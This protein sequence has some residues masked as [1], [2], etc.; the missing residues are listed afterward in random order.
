MDDRE[1][2]PQVVGSLSM[3]SPLRIA[4]IANRPKVSDS[5]VRPK[6]CF[7]DF[8]RPRPLGG[9]D[10]AEDGAEEPKVLARRTHGAL[11]ERSL[12]LALA[13]SSALR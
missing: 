1:F 2:V 9:G 5:V 6:N 7:I 12:A 11:I 3:I 10:G 4:E 13:M 8:H